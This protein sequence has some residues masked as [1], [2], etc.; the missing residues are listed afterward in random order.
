MDNPLL[1]TNDGKDFL[2]RACE[3]LFALE[4][5]LKDRGEQVTKIVLLAVAQARQEGGE[6][7]ATARV[8]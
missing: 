1:P 8:R 5:R 6:F 3:A 4:P 7:V 2:I